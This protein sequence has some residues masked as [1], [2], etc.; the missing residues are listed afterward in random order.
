MPALTTC[1]KCDADTRF[2][3]DSDGHWLCVYPAEC[4]LRAELRD[5][6]AE[7]DHARGEIAAYR[8]DV[9]EMVRQLR[10]Q[11]RDVKEERDALLVQVADWC[12]AVAAWKGGAT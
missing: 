10:G 6:T 8:L 11:V 4:A 1:V 12:A 7:R 3:H 2:A 9:A 5:V